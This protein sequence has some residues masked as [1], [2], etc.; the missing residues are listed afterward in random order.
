MSE[1]TPLHC[2]IDLLDTAGIRLPVGTTET[3]LLKNLHAALVK[4]LG[5]ETRRGAEDPNVMRL[6]G[7]DAAGEVMDLLAAN[8]MPVLDADGLP[9]DEEQFKA[10]VPTFLRRAVLAR[11]A[12]EKA[13]RQA[14]DGKR[15]QSERFTALGW[16][17]SSPEHNPLIPGA[18]AAM[19][20]ED[21]EVAVNA[22]SRFIH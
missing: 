15:G 16:G 13:Q 8:G 22:L 11:F 4:Q 20:L 3:N 17:G 18:D 14:G 6:R 2:A 1:I 5:D 7:A 10:N 9:V 12:G 21:E 19:S